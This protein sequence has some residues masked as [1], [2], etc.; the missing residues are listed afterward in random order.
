M[1]FQRSRTSLSASRHSILFGVALSW[2]LLFPSLGLFQKYLGTTRALVCMA[3]GVALFARLATTRWFAA[4]SR[5]EIDRGW[6][7]TTTAV[8]FAVLVLGFVV[9]YPMTNTAAAGQSPSSVSIGGGGSDR[10]ESLQLGIRELV[11]GRYPYYQTTPLDN[12][13]T[14][15]PGSL[16]LAV[17]FAWLGNAVWQNLFWF[18]VF[19]VFVGSVF[20][21]ERTTALVIALTVFA[22]PVVLQD[23]LTGGDLG[24]NTITILIGMFLMITLAP[25][26]SAATWKKITVAAFTGIALSSRLN[27]LLLMPPLFAAMARRAGLREAVWYVG[28]AALA[29]AAVTLPFYLYDPAHFAPLNLHNRFNQ[30][31]GE[32]RGGSIL[33]PALSLVVSVIVSFYSGNR[34]VRVWL[35]QSG[36]VL[37]LPVVFLV[38]VA[39]IRA[40]RL[41]FLFTD[42]ALAGAFFGAM[43]AGLSIFGR[44]L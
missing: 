3:I 16:L 34:T 38:G 10:D 23:F 7:S 18:G 27:F 22:S 42:Y 30:F 26:V 37:T 11:A 5:E 35:L 9:F 25:D 15:L 14:Q 32:V 28:V 8:L 1:P 41:N 6:M 17:P 36:F 21:S 12:F 13:V 24:V 40:G 2:F 29:F 19:I 4:P 20:Q 39:T 43:G 44:E 31:E 33:F